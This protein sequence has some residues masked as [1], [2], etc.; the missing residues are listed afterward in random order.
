MKINKSKI[1]NIKIHGGDGRVDP[2]FTF[3]LF[4]DLRHKKLSSTN[5]PTLLEDTKFQ[6]KGDKLLEY[7]RLIQGEPFNNF[8]SLRG[9]VAEKLIQDMLKSKGYLVETFELGEDITRYKESDN[10]L[11]KYFRGL[12][13]IIYTKQDGERHLLEIKSK[14]LSKKQYVVDNPP[15]TEIR[16]GKMLALLEDLDNVTMTYVMFGDDIE[17]KM[18]LAVEECNPYS[19]ECAYEK[20]MLLEPNLKLNQNFELHTKNYDVD[21]DE[22]LKE[23]KVA[24][25]YSEMFRQTLTVFMKDLSKEVRQQLFE[26]ERELEDERKAFGREI[27]KG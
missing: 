24:Y 10:A 22:V 2:H 11:Y 26:L 14:S 1:K 18:K 8:Y 6:K 21:R 3:V 9:Y 15:E 4:D 27:K 16:Q 19:N 17:R 12:P 25:K 13:D 7:F 23:M 5:Y 20:F